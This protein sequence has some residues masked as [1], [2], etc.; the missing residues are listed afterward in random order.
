MALLEFERILLAPQSERDFKTGFGSHA[1]DQ[2]EEP[3]A[4]QPL[5]VRRVDIKNEC[6]GCHA[7]DRCPGLRSHESGSLTATRVADTMETALAWKRERPDF[8]ALRK[9]LAK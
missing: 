3:L 8:K 1:Y 9:L 4:G 5:D 2:F 7:P 6:H